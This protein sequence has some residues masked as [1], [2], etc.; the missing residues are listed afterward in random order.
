VVLLLAPV[1]DRTKK[2]EVLVTIRVVPGVPVVGV[3]VVINPVVVGAGQF[4]G[5]KT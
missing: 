1:E 2:P 5:P 3:P 4:L